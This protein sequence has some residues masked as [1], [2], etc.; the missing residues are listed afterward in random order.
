M[1]TSACGD[2][3]LGRSDRADGLLAHLG[4]GPPRLLSAR[5]GWSF[6][7]LYKLLSLSIFQLFYCQ[8]RV[9]CA[10]GVY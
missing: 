8:W 3:Y 2:A 6:S 9:F 4:C 5:S 7:E 10:F 1:I